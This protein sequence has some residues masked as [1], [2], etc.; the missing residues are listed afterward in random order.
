MMEKSW[1]QNSSER[2]QILLLLLDDCLAFVIYTW[3][4]TSNKTHLLLTMMWRNCF[5][6]HNKINI[7]ITMKAMIC[8][9]VSIIHASLVRIVSCVKC[10][11]YFSDLDCETVDTLQYITIECWG[12]WE[13]GQEENI[14]SLSGMVDAGKI[15]CGM[16][17]SCVPGTGNYS[18]TWWNLVTTDWESGAGSS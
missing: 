12:L 4:N 7:L 3:L 6:A 8:N 14:K 16:V 11:K 5:N 13:H 2:E 10:D 18:D 17:I 15:D 1:F 9:R